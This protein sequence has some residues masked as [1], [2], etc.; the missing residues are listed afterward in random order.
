MGQHSKG[1]KLRAE[2]SC[3]GRS[4]PTLPRRREV[5]RG[6]KE[7]RGVSPRILPRSKESGK[8]LKGSEVAIGSGVS[9]N[10]KP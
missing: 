6:L 10:S 9:F 5:V 4:L 3:W 1:K 8:K 2:S 7:V